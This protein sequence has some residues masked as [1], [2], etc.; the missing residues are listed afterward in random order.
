MKNTYPLFLNIVATFVLLWVDPLAQWAGGIAQAS[1][2]A[3]AAANSYSNNSTGVGTRY[4]TIPA[5]AFKP[6]EDGYEL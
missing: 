1:P 6:F 2:P 4:L 5:A 3:R